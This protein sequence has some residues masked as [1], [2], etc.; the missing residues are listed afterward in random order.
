MNASNGT[1]VAALL[2]GA[3]V[4]LGGCAATPPPLSAAAA[5]R[6]AYALGP[7]DKLRI[8][9]YNE[10][11]LTGEYTVTPSST[12]A[13]PL[14]GD[15]PVTERTIDTLRQAITTRLADGYVNDPRVSVEVMTFRT[16]YIL[17][18]VNKP[19]E[20]PYS[21]GL[22]LEQAVATAG[23]YTY[24]ANKRRIFLRRARAEERSVDLRGTAVSVLPGDTVRVGE[25]YF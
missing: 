6:D 2:L 10:P 20:Y 23:G 16:Y 11:A 17:G 8:T 4:A 9:V 13:F 19:G 14:V 21:V 3:S 18:E 12:I 22:T 24:R 15:V 1:M 25:R 5:T 7:G